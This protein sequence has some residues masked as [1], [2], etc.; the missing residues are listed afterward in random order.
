ME[1]STDPNPSTKRQREAD[2]PSDVKTKRARVSPAQDENL[3]YLTPGPDAR[4]LFVLREPSD[5]DTD[6]DEER[7]ERYTGGMP[8]VKRQELLMRHLPTEI[9]TLSGIVTQLDALLMPPAEALVEAAAV[10]NLNRLN[11]LL[12]LFQCE[13]APAAIAAAERGHLDTVQLLLPKIPTTDDQNYAAWG[14]LSAA[15][16]HGHLDVV[17]FIANETRE[18]TNLDGIFPDFRAAF[19]LSDALP[20]AITGGHVDVVD[21]LLDPDTFHWDIGAA[22]EQAIKENKMEIAD[23]VYEVFTDFVDGEHHYKDAG[24]YTDT[25]IPSLSEEKQQERDLLLVHEARGGRSNAVKYLYDHGHNAPELISA[26]IVN[27]ADRG[28]VDAVKFLCDTGR[29]SQ[30]AFDT[31]F[32]SAARAGSVDA[33]KFLYSKNRVSAKALQNA[34]GSAASVDVVKFLHATKQI[35]D[36][37]LIKAFQ[38]SALYTSLKGVGF[39]FENEDVP[40]IAVYKA[41]EDAACRFSARAVQLMVEKHRPIPDW[42]IAKALRDAS[43]RGPIQNIVLE[44][45]EKRM[46]IVD[47]LSTAGCVPVNIITKAFMTA[48]NQNNADVVKVLFRKEQIISSDV[49]AKG[50]EVSANIG[51]GNVLRALISEQ[52][53]PEKIATKCFVAAAKNERMDIVVNLHSQ[54]RATASELCEI[55][56]CAATKEHWKVMMYLFEKPDLLQTLTNHTSTARAVGM[57]EK[58]FVAAASACTADALKILANDERISVDVVNKAFLKAVK[59]GRTEHT[60]KCLYETHRVSSEVIIKGFVHAANCGHAGAVKCLYQ[61]V[62]ISTSVICETFKTAATK[63]KVE[64]VRLLMEKKCLSRRVK[65][66]AFMGAAQHGRTGVIKIIGLA[67]SWTHK[68]LNKALKVAP[69]GKPAQR[70]LRGLVHQR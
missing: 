55:L 1:E 29:A 64:V 52:S 61:D 56:D 39:Q 16:A 67:E 20:Q 68:E 8:K 50:F 14:I 45:S 7:E 22:L 9:T 23:M 57:I 70:F 38:E 10:G 21:F 42:V 47:Y 63:G 18:L 32:E 35:R 54:Q 5:Q 4:M 43:R 31:A 37:A 51:R 41:L 33:V 62:N 46:E 24:Y 49:I 11:T 65:H 3:D 25:D 27:A 12:E 15:A 58:A 19:L 17:Q 53:I 28:H 36:D 26:A 40:A 69:E 48:V 60:V 66:E 6:T 34:F 30:Q 2:S 13:V 59:S 44:G